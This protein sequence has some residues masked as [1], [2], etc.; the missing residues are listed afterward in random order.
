MDADSAAAAAVAG[1]AVTRVLSRNICLGEGGGGGKRRREYSPRCQTREWREP[2][3]L[4]FR[5]PETQ[6]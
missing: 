2:K 1:V 3:I 4:N 5:P 6:V